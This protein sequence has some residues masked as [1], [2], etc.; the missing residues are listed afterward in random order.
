MLIKTVT[1]EV[2][3][4]TYWALTS[5]TL[6]DLNTFQIEFSKDQLALLRKIFSEI[7][8]SD[9]FISSTACL[10]FCSLL[11]TKLLKID[12]NE[13]LD[14]VVKRKWLFLK[15]GQYYMGVRSIAE[16][17]PYFK[18]TY[19][20]SLQ[21]CSICKEIIFFGKKCTH[22]ETIMHLACLKKYAKVTRSCRCATCA[23]H[24]EMDDDI[25]NH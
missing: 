21:S 8:T 12:A 11:D 19:E 4:D 1:C 24:I 9:G 22:C 5:T 7:I 13:F 3:G 15:N 23:N 20:D 14:D 17:M 25:V 18:A 10:N 2:A 16:L 6:Q